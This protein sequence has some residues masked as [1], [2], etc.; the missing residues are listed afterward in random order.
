[1][2]R[3]EGLINQSSKK[4][5]GIKFYKRAKNTKFKFKKDNW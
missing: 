3:G 5:E 1:M 4:D 2:I